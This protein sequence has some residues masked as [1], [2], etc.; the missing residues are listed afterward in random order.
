VTDETSLPPIPSR[1][2]TPA[3]VGPDHRI[4]TVERRKSLIERNQIMSNV[5]TVKGVYAAFG[6]GDMAMPHTAY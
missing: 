1:D 5:E 2:G 4:R 6:R 3:S